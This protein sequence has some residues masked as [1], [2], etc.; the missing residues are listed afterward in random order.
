M[1]GFEKLAGEVN[2]RQ[3]KGLAFREAKSTWRVMGEKELRIHVDL[4][5][6]FEEIDELEGRAVQ[7]LDTMGQERKR[8]G[9]K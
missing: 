3:E 1:C 5:D 2:T 7:G 9:F 8:L 4:E 6:R